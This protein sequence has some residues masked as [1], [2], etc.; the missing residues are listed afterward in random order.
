MKKPA[1][2]TLAL[3]ASAAALLLVSCGTHTPEARI[4]KHPAIYESLSSD[5]KELASRGQIASGMPKAGVFIALGNPDGRTHGE[6]D[7]RPYERWTYSSLEPVFR[8]GF[9]GYFGTGWSR[10]GR[11]GRRGYS[12]FG[13]SP[14]LYYL[15]VP[16]SW[17]DFKGDR[18]SGWETRR[19]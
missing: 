10:Y 17:V 5:H 15:P 4:K 8:H 12:G 13:Y 1:Q 18:V 14:H 19:R 16:S 11:Y 2:K 3:A 7:G 6:K 9:N